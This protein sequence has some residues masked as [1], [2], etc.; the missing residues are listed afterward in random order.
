[1]PSLER[2]GV[3]KQAF[4]DQVAAGKSFIPLWKCWPADLETPLTTWLK[5]GASSSHGALL[6]SVE[7]G[8][9]IGRWSFVVSDPRSEEQHV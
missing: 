6:E 2:D 1:M 4:L 5:V 9:R 3:A 8:E 7:G